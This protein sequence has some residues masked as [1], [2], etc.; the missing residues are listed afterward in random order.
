[1]QDIELTLEERNVFG[2]K[3][4][5]LRRNGLVPAV[6]HNHGKD[7]II[8]MGQQVP[9]LKAYQEAGKHQTVQL[10]VGKQEYMA[11]IKDA[12]FEPT[13]QQLRHLVFNAV[14]KDQKVEAEVPVHVEGDI[15][16]ERAGHMVVTNLY[17]VIVEAK[18]GDM[19]ESLSVSG[20]ALAEI[21][22]K[23]TVADIKLPAGVAVL[24]EPDQVVAAV[25]ETKAEMSEESTAEETSATDVPSDNGG[26]EEAS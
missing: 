15:P 25:E 23:V 24:T 16:A 4:K 3:V 17:H 21:G 22:D 5:S 14:K 12:D 18:P 13:K 10:K 20:E 19:P 9:M 26:G 8:V 1:M 6:I 2:K 7:S 11:M